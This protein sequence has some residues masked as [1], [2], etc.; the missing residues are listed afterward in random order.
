MF[1]FWL[2]HSHSSLQFTKEAHPASLPPVLQRY[3]TYSFIIPPI[4]QNSK[5][6]PVFDNQRNLKFLIQSIPTLFLPTYLPHRKNSNTFHTLPKQLQKPHHRC[7]NSSVAI[8]RELLPDSTTY[9][10]FR[11]R[12][13]DN[14]WTRRSK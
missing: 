11:H 6:Y 14:L 3:T 7:P 1:G 10:T 4:Q 9:E 13:M 8:L 2:H 5:N 12:A